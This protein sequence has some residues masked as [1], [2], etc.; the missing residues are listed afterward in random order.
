MEID[1]VRNLIKPLRKD[2][3]TILHKWM[4]RALILSTCDIDEKQKKS[5]VKSTNNPPHICLLLITISYL[6]FR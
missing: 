4:N 6:R 2:S 5:Y 1:S 3:D